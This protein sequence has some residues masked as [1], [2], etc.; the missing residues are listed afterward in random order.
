M[1]M[2]NYTFSESLIERRGG[3]R[4]LKIKAEKGERT[5][6]IVIAPWRIADYK[7]NFG[8]KIQ[9]RNYKKTI[10]CIL[11]FMN[12]RLVRSNRK[13]SLNRDFQSRPSRNNIE[14]PCVSLVKNKEL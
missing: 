11:N 3:S 1:H 2:E 7:N 10:F 13:M 4:L 5:Y 8:T 6:C 12:A 9:N 14:T